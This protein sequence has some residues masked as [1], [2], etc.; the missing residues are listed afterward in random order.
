M[1]V[2]TGER[3]HPAGVRAG[4]FDPQLGEAAGG[5][6]TEPQLALAISGVQ[7]P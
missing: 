2:Q 3:E 7:R 5:R 6:W 1:A 4:Q